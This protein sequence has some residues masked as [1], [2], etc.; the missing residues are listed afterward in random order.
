MEDYVAIRA[1]V[2]AALKEDGCSV[3]LV[4]TSTGELDT[5]T[6]QYPDAVTVTYPGAAILKSYSIKEIDGSVLQQGDRKILLALDDPGVV[7]ATIDNL[8]VLGVLYAIQDVKPADPAGM[9]I[10]YEI[11]ARR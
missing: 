8:D 1:E 5:V 10:L 4:V 6:G 11:Q 7:P 9:A 3:S 2:L